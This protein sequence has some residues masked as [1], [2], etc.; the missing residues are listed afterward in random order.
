MFFKALGVTSSHDTYVGGL[1]VSLLSPS[2]SPGLASA[3]AAL[4]MLMPAQR[5]S[6]LDNNHTICLTDQPLC[7]LVKLSNPTADQPLIG[8]INCFPGTY[9]L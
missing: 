6:V 2:P 5:Q 7:K 1:D 3:T 4:S 9:K 8:L